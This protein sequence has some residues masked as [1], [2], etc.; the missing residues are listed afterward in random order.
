MK[1]TTIVTVPDNTDAETVTKL[2]DSLDE[3]AKVSVEELFYPADVPDGIVV[4]TEKAA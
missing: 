2:A 3:S 4:I 1:I